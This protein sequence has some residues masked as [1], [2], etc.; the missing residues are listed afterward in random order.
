MNKIFLLLALS[1][2]L[3]VTNAKQVTKSTQK[4]DILR[5]RALNSEDYIIKLNGKD[6][7]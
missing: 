4:V 3:V 1:S 6:Y 5:K 7:K 2:L